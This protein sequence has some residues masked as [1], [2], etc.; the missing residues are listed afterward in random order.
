MK[1]S[2]LLNKALRY[3]LGYVLLITIIIATGYY[4]FMVQYHS[5]TMDE[6]LLLQREKN[7]EKRLRTLEVSEIHSWNRFNDSE[8]ILPDTGQAEENVFATE[9]IFSEFGR[10]LEPHRALYSRVEI[11]GEKYILAIRLNFFEAQKILQFSAFSSLLLFVGIV[12]GLIIITGRIH[13]KLWKPFYQTLSLSE[14]FNIQQNEIPHF[15]STGTQEFEQLNQMLVDLFDQNLQTYKIQR[16]FAEN[17][18]QEMQAPLAVFRSTLDMLLQLPGLTREQLDIIQT[19]HEENLRLIH[20][21]DN[22]LLLVQLDNLQFPDLQLLNIADTVADSLSFHSEQAEAANL[23][24]ET[25]LIDRSLTLH[26]NRQLLDGLINN[27]IINSIKHNVPGGRILVTLHGNRLDIVNTSM[28]SPLDY[29]ILFR[30]FGR[31]D[32]AAKGSGLGLAIAQQICTLYG[33]QIIYGFAGGMHRFTVN[34]VEMP[35]YI[36]ADRLLA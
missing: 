27:L 16:E 32:P 17:T 1:Q 11:E 14:Q 31:M 6:L 22:L 12:A 21:N 3:Y 8:T 10:R 33:W 29:A 5:H 24:V 18:A 30:R 23:A 2:K 15:P 9:Y 35:E 25:Y 26:A 34:F 28:E 7:V 36:K 4:L 20:M 13:K 19:V